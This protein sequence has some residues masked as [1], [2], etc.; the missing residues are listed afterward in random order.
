MDRIDFG[1]RIGLSIFSG[2]FQK[3]RTDEDF[4]QSINS[5]VINKLCGVIV[6]Y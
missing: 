2:P 3:H 5:D 6:A 4:S 1:Q